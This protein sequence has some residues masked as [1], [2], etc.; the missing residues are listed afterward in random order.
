MVQ[1]LTECQGAELPVR[2][3]CVL[4][5]FWPVGKLLISVKISTA[6]YDENNHEIGEL[7]SDKASSSWAANPL[8]RDMSRTTLV[9][10]NACAHSP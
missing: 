4:V 5:N 10:L 9:R 3:R 1:I 2:N 6:V 8:A 7:S